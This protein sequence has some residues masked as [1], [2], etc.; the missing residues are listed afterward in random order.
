MGLGHTLCMHSCASSSRCP[1][2]GAG[3]EAGMAPLS[4]GCHRAIEWWV[5]AV[6]TDSLCVRFATSCQ[7][8]GR[9]GTWAL[10]RV[11]HG[12]LADDSSCLHP[13]VSEGH[14]LPRSSACRRCAGELADMAVL[15]T[16][17]CLPVASLAGIRDLTRM[18]AIRCIATLQCQQAMCRMALQ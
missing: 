4:G 15:R 2:L 7:W 18:A 3:T 17:T 5:S 13:I 6:V 16:G 10:R 8:Q 1:S 12:V 9:M 14:I 11:Q